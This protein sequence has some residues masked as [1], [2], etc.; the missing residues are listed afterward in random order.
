MFSNKHSNFI[1]NLGAA[2]AADVASLVREAQ[3]LRFDVFA[4]EMGAVWA[5]GSTERPITAT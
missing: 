1:E 2:S 4:R 5:G 3:R